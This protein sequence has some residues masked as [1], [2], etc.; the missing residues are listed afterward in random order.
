MI[1]DLLDRYF[2]ARHRSVAWGK[3]YFVGK[4]VRAG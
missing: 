4:R 2:E 1:L 3:L